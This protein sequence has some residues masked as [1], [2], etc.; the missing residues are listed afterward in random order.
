[1]RFE[2]LS[3]F[4][5]FSFHELDGKQVCRITIEPAP[6]PV[7]VKEGNEDQLYVRAGNATRRVTTKEAVDYTKNRFQT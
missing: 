4:L 5:K 6:R 3:R 7:W 1:M 2:D